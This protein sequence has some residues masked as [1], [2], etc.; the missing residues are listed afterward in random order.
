MLVVCTNCQ[1]R[2]RVPEAAAGKKGKCPK[3]GTILSVPPAE[4]PS[5]EAPA[6][7]PAPPAP[8]Q[9]EVMDA[10]PFP[11]TDLSYAPEP[12]ASSS[13]RPLPRTT[14]RADDLDD[15][16]DEEDEPPRRRR[17]EDGDDRPR[18]RRD[19][20]DDNRPRRRDDL[21]VRRPRQSRGMSV[22]SMV[23]GI[24]S[25]VVLLLS[26]GAMIFSAALLTC[27]CPLGCLAGPIGYAG[28]ALSAILA[29]VAAPLG[30]LGM[31]RGG[32]G[33][34]IAGIATGAAT[35]VLCLVLLVVTLIFGAAAVFV[36]ANA[37]PQPGLQ[38]GRPPFKR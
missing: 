35:L 11:P 27:A 3:C 13:P 32:K 29:L 34:A 23:V 21:D 2:I 33:M 22:A 8:E 6:P 37:Q 20:A 31:S 15:D 19:E 16:D 24:G 7:A 4:A 14:R 12:P 5:S 28:I 18:G 9:T 1:A 17:D 26:G 25:L 10:P 36:G 38:P 30:F